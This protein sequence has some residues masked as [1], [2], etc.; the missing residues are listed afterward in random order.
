MLKDPEARQVDVTK[1]EELIASAMEKLA[2]NTK[3]FGQI[4]KFVS[5]W[6]LEDFVIDNTNTGKNNI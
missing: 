4:S 6:W 3:S 5:K 2:E 1:E